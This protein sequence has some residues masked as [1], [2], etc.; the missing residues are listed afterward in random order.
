MD[1]VCLFYRT[2][3]YVNNR[4]KKRTVITVRFFLIMHYAFFIMHYLLNFHQSNLT[5]PLAFWNVM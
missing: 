4:K 1:V 5:S 3:I 2:A